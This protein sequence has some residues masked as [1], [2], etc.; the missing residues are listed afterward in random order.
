MLGNQLT[1]NLAMFFL[2]RPWQ[3]SVTVNKICCGNI[4]GICSRRSYLMHERVREGTML[5]RDG[6]EAS[7]AAR[8]TQ[9]VTKRGILWPWEWTQSWSVVATYFFN[10]CFRG[11]CIICPPPFCFSLRNYL[12]IWNKWAATKHSPCKTDHG[13]IG[14][15]LKYHSHAL[16]IGTVMDG[17]IIML[18]LM[19]FWIFRM[20]FH[21]DT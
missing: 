5:K 11:T 1:L 15:F 13:D 19:Y 4:K 16:I 3:N 2:C 10:K 6:Y 14:R 21:S 18:N 8:E 7:T 9:S 17:D 12:R 20:N